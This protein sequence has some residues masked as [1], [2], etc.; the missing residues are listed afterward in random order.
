MLRDRPVAG[1]SG[2]VVGVVTTAYSLMVGGMWGRGQA[3]NH[4]GEYNMVQK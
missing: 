4:A 3:H 1:A 2:C